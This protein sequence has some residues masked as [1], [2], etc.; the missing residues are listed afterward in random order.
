MKIAKNF[1]K[2]DKYIFL[3]IVSLV[4]G[5][6]GGSLM[7]VRVLSV[8][9]LPALFL[10]INYCQ[11]YA[12]K[13]YKFFILFYAFCIMSFA[14]TPD[15]DQALKELLYYPVHFLIFLEIIVFS[16]FSRDPLKTISTS[17]LICV[18][19]TSIIAMWEI[20]TSN[21]LALS[22]FEAEDVTLNVGG[23]ISERP[24][25]AV[26][27]GNFNGYV[28]FLCFAMPFLF[29]YLMQN[30]GDVKNVLLSMSVFFATIVAIL[31]DASRGGLLTILIMGL[32]LFLMT[33]RSVYKVG[34][35][36]AV[37][38]FIV[39]FIL[40][41][42]DTMFVAMALKSEGGNLYTDESRFAIWSDG[43][44][45]LYNY[46]F[47]GSGVGS[48][49]AAMRRVTTGI[50][51]THNMFLEVLVQFGVVFFVVFMFYL[52]RLFKRGTITKDRNIKIMLY[53]ALIALPIYSIIDSGYLLNPVIY[54]AFASLTVFAYIDK[55][56]PIPIKKAC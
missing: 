41:N 7:I 2:Y 11:D 25:A 40:P 35:L 28:A 9:L 38:A 29:Y 33:K 39:Y 8:L 6:F 43:L 17:W 10:K 20:T 15:K 26:T 44:K 18:G 13:Y 4:F 31:V 12:S 21:H 34:L 52:L 36:L 14:W 32:I 37:I 27:F 49:S 42:M 56:H 19:I 53:M 1:N 3:L 55:I 16:R 22:K 50:T 5:G 48:I 46:I 47:V 30:R 23:V 51:I 24:F 54:A 45:V